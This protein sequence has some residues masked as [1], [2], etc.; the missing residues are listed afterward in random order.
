MIAELYNSEEKSMYNIAYRW[1]WN[2]EDAMDL[3][4][5]AFIRFSTYPDFTKIEKPK[6]FLYRILQNLCANRVRYRKLWSW[7]S[8]NEEGYEKNVQIEKLEGE[9]E[10]R[11][12]RRRIDQLSPKLKK[13]LLMHY[14]SEMSYEDISEVLEVPVGTVS[15]RLNQAIHILRK[16]VK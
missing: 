6:C 9:E 7:V 4:H 15:S 12:L 11:N 16:S 8:W 2:K 3:V 14:F 10:S 13:T 1:V 5:D